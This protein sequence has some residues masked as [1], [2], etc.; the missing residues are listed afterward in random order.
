MAS[1]CTQSSIEQRRLNRR[2]R[3]GRVEQAAWACPRLYKKVILAETLRRLNERA[4]KIGTAPMRMS[5]WQTDCRLI[6]T[7]N[8][9]LMKTSPNRMMKN[10]S[11]K[12]SGSLLTIRFRRRNWTTTTRSRGQNCGTKSRSCPRFA[13]RQHRHHDDGRLRRQ[14][15]SADCGQRAVPS[16]ADPWEGACKAAQDIFHGD[17]YRSGCDG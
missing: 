11:L 9:S 14:C 13:W 7:T 8:S 5:C 12:R 17:N 3:E 4:P 1:L 10:W 6:R 15:F 2:F 16:A